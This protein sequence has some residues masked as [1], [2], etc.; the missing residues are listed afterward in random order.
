MRTIP[1][2]LICQTCKFP[3]IA[4]RAVLY[5]GIAGGL[6]PCSI[7]ALWLKFQFSQTA[8][9]AGKAI[10]HINSHGTPINIHYMHSFEEWVLPIYYVAW[11]HN[12][13]IPK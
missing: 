13:N 2:I 6:D 5:S 12:P 11:M 7:L 9:H 4:L 1:A 3:N 8:F 10:V